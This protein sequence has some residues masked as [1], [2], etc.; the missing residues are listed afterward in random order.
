MIREPLP[1]VDYCGMNENEKCRHCIH[2]PF[3]YD[4]CVAIMGIKPVRNSKT[5]LSCG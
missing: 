1:T 3:V 4:S 2:C 5:C